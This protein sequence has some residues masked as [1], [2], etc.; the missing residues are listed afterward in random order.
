MPKNKNHSKK[1]SLYFSIA[2]LAVAV[3]VTLYLSKGDVYDVVS[4]EITPG[5]KLL[6]NG[7]IKPIKPARHCIDGISYIYMH[8]AFTGG[9]SPEY[10]NGLPVTCDG[11]EPAKWNGFPYRLRISRLCWNGQIYYYVHG[12]KGA[13]ISAAISASG[14]GVQC[15]EKNLKNP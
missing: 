15:N 7:F 6:T 4:N 10:I 14:K 2:I 12:Y 13:A 11:P 9:M 5:D 8:E 1:R 3:A